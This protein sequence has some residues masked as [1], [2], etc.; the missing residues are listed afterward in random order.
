MQIE[1][2]DQDSE[3]IMIEIIASMLPIFRQTN[4]SNISSVLS[5]LLLMMDWDDISCTYC[6]RIEIHIYKVSDRSVGNF[7][8]LAF[9]RFLI[10]QVCLSMFDSTIMYSQLYRMYHAFNFWLRLMFRVK[11][12]SNSGAQICHEYLHMCRVCIF[13]K[14]DIDLSGSTHCCRWWRSMLEPIVQVVMVWF[15]CS[16]T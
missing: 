15:H 12:C 13:A 5:L 7:H 9:S 14:Y 8:N 4:T 3:R 1:D 16:Y 10:N 6:Y 2:S 11:K